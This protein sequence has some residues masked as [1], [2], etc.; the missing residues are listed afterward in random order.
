[1]AGSRNPLLQAPSRKMP[2]RE[3][4]SAFGERRKLD[5]SHTG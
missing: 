3:G 4:I 2:V 1:M 5:F